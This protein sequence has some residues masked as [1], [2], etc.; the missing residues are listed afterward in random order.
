MNGDWSRPFVGQEEILN[1]T[2]KSPV[3]QNCNNVGAEDIRR[4]AAKWN[5]T[6]KIHLRVECLGA[7]W[8][9][10]SQL[11]TVTL[12]NRVTGE[13]FKRTCQIFVP[14]VGLFGQPRAIDVPGLRRSRIRGADVLSRGEYVQS[15]H[16]SFGNVETRCSPTGQ[17]SRGHR[18][19]V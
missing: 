14:A 12:R 6:D 7:E 8:S 4:E 3:H 9:D 1:C 11:W 13:T 17:K 19:W 16:L 5:L 18:E 10:E 15:G 2:P